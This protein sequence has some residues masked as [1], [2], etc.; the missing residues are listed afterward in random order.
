M[1][2]FQ[3]VIAVLFLFLSVRMSA[4][5]LIQFKGKVIDAETQ[6]GLPGAVISIPD[7]RVSAITNADGEFTLKNIPGQGSFLVQIRYMG[8]ETMSKMVDFANLDT[9]SF[10]L[11]QSVIEGREVVIT[12]TATSSSSR[13][14]STS[15]STVSKAELLSHPSTNL[16][17]ALSRV[18]GVSQITTGNGISKP[19]IRGLSGNRVLTLNNGV[20]QQ[21]QQWGD[22][23]GLEIDQYSADRLEILRGPA[24]L[25]Y[26]SDALGGVINVL[27]ALPAPEGTVQGE[28]LSNYATNSGLTGSSLMLQGNE[29]GFVYRARGS[30]KNAHSFKTPTGYLPNSGFNETN[31]NGQVGLNKQWGYAHLDV[32]SFRSNLGFYE[33]AVNAA[34]QFIDE[35]GNT[36]TDDQLTSRSLAFPKQDVRHFKLALNSN[37]LFNSGSLKTTLGYQKNNRKEL[38][39]ADEAPELMLNMHTYNYDFKYSFKPVNGWAPVIGTS[40]EFIH[41]IN[42]EGLEALIPDFDSQSYGAFVYVK[43]TWDK[44]TINAGVRYDY[45]KLDGKAHEAEGEEVFQ[46]FSNKFSNVSAGLGYTHEFNEQLGF[47]ANAG[48]AFRAPNIAELSSNG[49][50]EG[51]FRYEIGNKDLKAEQSYQ[52]DASLDYQTNTLS[53]SIGGFVN[54]INNFIFYNTTGETIDDMQVYRSI[55]RNALLRGLEASL[56]LHPVEFLHFENSFSYTRATNKATDQP[57]PFIPAA[58]LRNEIRFEPSIKGTQKTYL[59]V[60]LDNFFKQNRVDEFETTTGAYTLF[61]AA[62]GTTL[63]L[64]KA[65]EL[66]LYVS[67]RNLLDKK[68]YDHLSRF[69]P[70]RLDAADPSFGIYNPGRNITFGVI[71]P[72]NLKN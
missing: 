38:E 26:G 5:V 34:G 29:N 4:A 40:G 21:G 15:I 44:N 3:L 24:S 12:G 46:N 10:S 47:K 7:L 37:I 50:H 59:S 1:K 41:S 69:K 35:D 65:Q 61:N 25:L 68:Y 11:K 43:K 19:V 58:A 31:F 6:Q 32:S 27:D 39:A 48:S 67:G 66:S 16:V 9:N 70:G 52:F 28:F 63:K 62:V 14:N 36:F 33:P 45:H 56:T 64:G 71:M 49:V 53:A 20:K 72:F 57:L 54:H 8:Y 18:P 30:Y 2:R 60:G 55:Q 42:T 51:T 13:K 23:H 22:E 17:D